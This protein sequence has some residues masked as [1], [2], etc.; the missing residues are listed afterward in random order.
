MDTLFQ[1]GV[2]WIIA[3]QALGGW[4]EP[5]M[6]VFI[7]PGSDYFFF[8]HPGYASHRLVY[9]RWFTMLVFSFQISRV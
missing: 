1:L 9:L 5:P 8:P 3:I 4:L 7:F 2:H 6:R